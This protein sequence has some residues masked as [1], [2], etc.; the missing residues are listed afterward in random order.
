MVT[1]ER[2]AGGD[3]L[4]APPSVGFPRCRCCPVP[5]TAA[6]RRCLLCPEQGVP[7]GNAPRR[8][9]ACGQQR[10]AGRP[11]PTPW[12]GRP[13]RAWS[14]AF[15]VGEYTGALR[16][17]ILRYKYA[18]ERWRAGAFARLIAG[19]LDRNSGWFDDFGVI[20]GTPAYTGPGARRSWDPVGHILAE[21]RPIVGATWSVHPE[22]VA[23][24]RE[25]PPLS[26]R[27]AGE[28]WTTAVGELRDALVVPRSEVVRGERVLLLDD[29]MAEGSTLH[30]V[31]RALRS[32]GAVEVAGLVLARPAWAAVGARSSPAG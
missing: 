31:G 7:G 3:L 8:C 32:A 5:R 2:A 28:R 16:Y 26:G 20:V 10:V 23:K 4:P 12:C 19:Y 6:G 27:S 13:D 15:S 9:A 22:V 21:L 1:D 11:C 25:T 30:E 18:G 24:Q 29:V 17:A 14:V